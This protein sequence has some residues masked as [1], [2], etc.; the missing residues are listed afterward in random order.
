MSFEDWK[1]RPVYVTQVFTWSLASMLDLNSVYFR[2]LPGHRD[3]QA[4]LNR[5]VVAEAVRF[6]RARRR[7]VVK[8]NPAGQ[9]TWLWAF[10]GPGGVHGGTATAPDVRGALMSALTSDV[11]GTLFGAFHGVPIEVVD[12]LPGT[13][14]P[15]FEVEGSWGRLT[16]VKAQ[17]A[18]PDQKDQAA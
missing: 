7:G 17:N 15:K 16:A 4:R 12:M 18:L 3:N 8:E 2:C 14:Q 11:H 6:E 5:R 1:R 13:L 10:I 9:L